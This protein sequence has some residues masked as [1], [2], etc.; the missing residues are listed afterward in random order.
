M[1]KI[2]KIK[3][4]MVFAVLCLIS[5]INVTGIEAKTDS[6]EPVIDLSGNELNDKDAGMSKKHNMGISDDIISA[7]IRD[8]SIE[9]PVQK[10]VRKIPAPSEKSDD[11]YIPVPT[12]PALAEE[13]KEVDVDSGASDDEFMPGE[14][15]IRF[16]D[17]YSVSKIAKLIPNKK[18]VKAKDIFESVYNSAKQNYSIDSSRLESLKEEI[19]KYFVISISDKSKKSVLN[20]IKALKKVPIVK[21]AEPNYISK[22]CVVPNDYNNYKLWNMDRIQMPET[23]NSY[24]GKSI[25]VGVLDTG[26]DSKHPDLKRNVVTSL[27]WNCARK[28][29]TDT[30]D[31]A[32][33]GT[34][35]AGTIGAEADN[36]IGVV[37]VNPF[38]RLVPIKI[39]ISNTNDYST[40]DLMAEG[41]LHATKNNIPVCNMSYSIPDSNVFRDAIKK[42]GQN[43]GTF[44]VSAGNNGICVDDV[45]AYKSLTKLDN[46]I[47]VTGSDKND[48]RDYGLNYGNPVHVAA[49]GTNIWSTVPTSISASGYISWGGTS[50]AAP[51]VAGVV[52]LLKGINPDMTPYEI[53][54]VIMNCSDPVPQL[55]GKVSSGGRLNAKNSVGAYLRVTPN[56]NETMAAAIKRSLGSRSGSDIKMIKLLGTNRMTEGSSSRDSANAILPNL[57]YADVSQYKNDLKKY[58]FYGCKNLTTVVLGDKDVK[59]P[60]YCFMNCTKLSTIYRSNN[61]SRKVNETDLTGLIGSSKGVAAQT[62]C[63]WG[64]TSLKAVKLPNSAKLRFSDN[65][66]DHCSNLD[67]VYMDTQIPVTGEADLTEFTELRPCIFRGTGITTVKLPKDVNIGREAFENCT[68]LKNIQLHPKQINKISVYD[69]SFYNVNK[70]CKVYM[71]QVLHKSSYNF[72]RSATE[73]IPKQ[74]NSLLVWPIENEKMSDAIKYYLEEESLSASQINNLVISGNVRMGDSDNYESAKVLPNLKV[75][76][77]SSFTGSL[78]TEAFYN[79]RNLKTVIR[80]SQLSEIPA[81]CFWECTKLNTMLEN[82]KYPK[83]WNELDLTDLTGGL[84][85]S[86]QTFEWC[87][88][89]TT[90]RLP[91]TSIGFAGAFPNCTSLSTIYKDG[92]KKQEGTFDL[93]GVSGLWTGW[94]HNFEN[95]AVKTVK[96]PRGVN[97]PEYCFNNCSKLEEILFERIQ[98]Y[99]IGIG[100]HA[101]YGVKPI[102]KAYMDPMLVYNNN[103][104]IKRSDTQNI[105]KVAY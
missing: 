71:N 10:D 17:K 6:Y 29:N 84:A 76:D 59:L 73:Y 41:I 43:G 45:Q 79:C 19:G 78:G 64:C 32:G 95:T 51:H 54:Q 11:S 3:L 97:I 56:T 28:S 20:I 72:H 42:Y 92:D 39:C 70:Q 96:L 86:T 7:L 85:I 104:Q 91:S 12:K 83:I 25:K 53:R 99:T 46:V 31:Y 75:V 90:V 13:E 89:I 52:S 16:K 98:I 82:N 5:T 60:A 62:Q 30:M 8:K 38:A 100:S 58:S 103:F 61:D 94:G 37:G 21:Y 74:I 2:L 26:I 65:V 27:G 63:F 49:P 23:W 40:G 22:P 87:E 4:I 35:V 66:F 44:I 88:N 57:Q 24:P 68:K 48:S 80:N 55:R 18:I 14:I 50:M 34:H 33:H 15:I 69:N 67:T 105:T 47:I 101:F 77:M 93:T 9:S 36:S 81:R 102:C 1:K